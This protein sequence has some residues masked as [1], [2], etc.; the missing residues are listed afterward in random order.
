MGRGLTNQ[1]IADELGVSTRAVEKRLTSCYRKL[2][3]AGRRE[4]LGGRS[5]SE[6][7]AAR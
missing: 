7:F 5:A 4:L 1:E 2:G 3:V 6:L